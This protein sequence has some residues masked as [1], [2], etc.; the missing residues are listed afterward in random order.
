MVIQQ[1]D[2]ATSSWRIL[3]SGRSSVEAG[4]SVALDVGEVLSGVADGDVSMF[5]AGFGIPTLS[6]VLG[7]G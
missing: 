4:F 2:A 1:R 3:R 5:V 6:T 7:F